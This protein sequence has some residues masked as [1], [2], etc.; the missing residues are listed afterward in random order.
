MGIQTLA[1]YRAWVS[2]KTFVLKRLETNSRPRRNEKKEKKQVNNMP[3]Q[4]KVGK[5]TSGKKEQNE[6]ASKPEKV[7]GGGTEHRVNPESSQRKGKKKARKGT[8]PKKKRKNDKWRGTSLHNNERKGR[9]PQRKGKEGETTTT[10]S[11]RLKRGDLGLGDKGGN[12]AGSIFE[13][14]GGRGG[15]LNR[16]LRGL[17]GPWEVT[18]KKIQGKGYHVSL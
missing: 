13:E 14:G 15:C 4:K 16:T 10:G 9:T 8:I 5:R 2:K 11:R 18:G 6:K 1:A 7:K 3:V 17:F 12:H